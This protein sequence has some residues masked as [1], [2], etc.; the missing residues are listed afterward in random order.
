MRAYHSW[1]VQVKM[2]KKRYKTVW[3]EF[4][5]AIILDLDM[6]GMMRGDFKI[7]RWGL[8]LNEYKRDKRDK[9]KIACWYIVSKKGNP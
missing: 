2:V 1:G 8:M 4:L 3:W 5:T 9:S 6:G 7:K